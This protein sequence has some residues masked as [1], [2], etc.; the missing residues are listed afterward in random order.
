MMISYNPPECV[1]TV[2]DRA[3]RVLVCQGVVII[4]KKFVKAV[5]GLPF[6]LKGIMLYVFFG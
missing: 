6:D 4:R 2:K 5:C 1:D 3:H